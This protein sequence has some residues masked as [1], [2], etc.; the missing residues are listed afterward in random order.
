MKLHVFLGLILENVTLLICFSSLQSH[1]HYGWQSVSK[2]LYFFYV[3][4]L[5]SFSCVTVH[6]SH[7]HAQ[8]DSVQVQK[9]SRQCHVSKMSHKEIRFKF[10]FVQTKQWISL[11]DGFFRPFVL[12]LWESISSIVERCEY[13]LPCFLQPWTYTK[14]DKEK[15]MVLQRTFRWIYTLNVSNE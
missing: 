7:L 1:L 15:K 3:S 9:R 12:M 11:N 10:V 5:V 13:P 4:R 6:H 14:T 8:L 2:R